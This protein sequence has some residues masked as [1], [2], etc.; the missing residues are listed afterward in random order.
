[1]SITLNQVLALAAALFSV[2]LFGALTRKS[3]IIVVLC[4]EL[5]FN[6]VNINLVAFTFFSGFTALRGQAFA[7]FVMVVSAAEMGLAM[8][9][10]ILLYRNRA[11]VEVDK[12][13]LM[14]W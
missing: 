8:A 4:I 9:I 11:T 5:M 7:I 2:G 10:A 14:K 13:N 6:A 1:L 3:V 12:I